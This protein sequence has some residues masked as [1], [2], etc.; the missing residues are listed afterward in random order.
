MTHNYDTPWKK[1]PWNLK[2]SFPCFV[3]GFIHFLFFR[4]CLIFYYMTLKWFDLNFCTKND[5]I[6]HSEL[7]F[8][9]S[10]MEK[11]KAEVVLKAFAINFF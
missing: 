10:Y 11:Q 2:W 5:N 9:D 7:S 1:N 3:S 8:Y 6:Y 4:T